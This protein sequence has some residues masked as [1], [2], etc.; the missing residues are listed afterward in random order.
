MLVSISHLVE[1]KIDGQDETCQVV[2]PRVC[3]IAGERYERYR[4]LMNDEGNYIDLTQQVDGLPPMVWPI[5]CDIIKMLD[6]ELERRVAAERE[7]TLVF[8]DEMADGRAFI[9]RQLTETGE[10]FFPV[11]VHQNSPLFAKL[12]ELLTDQNYCDTIRG[13]SAMRVVPQPTTEAELESLVDGALKKYSSMEEFAW[14]LVL[15]I[16]K[17]MGIPS[18]LVDAKQGPVLSGSVCLI[19]VK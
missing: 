18:D 2:Q 9:V 12:S 5:N 14:D 7:V 13:R 16:M 1:L 11:L 6:H 15:E 17:E 10:R 8:P 19:G 4:C 3:V